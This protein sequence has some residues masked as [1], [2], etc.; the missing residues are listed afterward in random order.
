MGYNSRLDELQAALL[1]R[2]YLPLVEDWTERRHQVARRYYDG[3]RHRSIF[4]RQCT[5]RIRWHS[6]RSTRIR[7]A[8]VDDGPSEERWYSFCGTFCSSL[9][10]NQRSMGPIEE[11]QDLRRARR[12]TQSEISIPIRPYLRDEEV[13]H[14]IAPVTAGIRQMLWLVTCLREPGQP[15][16]PAGR[17]DEAR[18]PG[19]RRARSSTC[20]RWQS[21]CCLEISRSRLPSVPAV[22]CRFP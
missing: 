18:G 17:A 12:I 3:I 10:I 19:A 21:G 4:V 16:P 14:S 11:V 8:V 13:S 5:D 15:R 6:F 1:N 7:N 22:S 9:R 2:V 20:G